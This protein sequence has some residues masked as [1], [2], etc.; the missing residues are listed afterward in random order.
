MTLCCGSVSAEIHAALRLPLSSFHRIFRLCTVP[1]APKGAGV[2]PAWCPWVHP[3]VS[4]A[5]FCA[6]QFLRSCQN[7]KHTSYH[8]VCY[9]PSLSVFEGCL[10]SVLARNYAV[11]CGAYSHLRFEGV[12]CVTR[13]GSPAYFLNVRGGNWYVAV[14]M[15]YLLCNIFARFGRSAENLARSG[16]ISGIVTAL[17][18]CMRAVFV[19]SP[20]LVRAG[21]VRFPSIPSTPV[22]VPDISVNRIR[23]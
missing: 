14:I 20:G 11:Y 13:K 2:L 19:V 15:C 8:F 5:P 10:Y 1:D 6:L 22:A 18:G 23:G 16:A 9:E 17:L 3:V 7:I 12:F 21:P 4:A